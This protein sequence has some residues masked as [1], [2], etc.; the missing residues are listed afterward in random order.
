MWQKGTQMFPYHLGSIFGTWYQKENRDRIY[1]SPEIAKNRQ[2][3][4]T[5]MSHVRKNN[6][7]WE[8]GRKWLQPLIALFL[9]LDQVAHSR[10]AKEPE[11]FPVTRR[12]WK[13]WW[14]KT[15]S[16]HRVLKKRALGGSQEH[17]AGCRSRCADKGSGSQCNRNNHVQGFHRSQEQHL[18]LPVPLE[19]HDHETP[20]RV[21]KASLWT[22]W[23]LLLTRHSFPNKCWNQD[24]RGSVLLIN[25][26][27]KKFQE[28]S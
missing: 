2:E 24:I 18:F 4:E 14:A 28:H 10:E 12:G 13:S 7:L 27:V 9:G 3:N 25:F 22:L 11:D 21:P 6:Y 23:K 26:T 5:H 1:P 20:S 16:I 17:S 19:S 15:T 8:T